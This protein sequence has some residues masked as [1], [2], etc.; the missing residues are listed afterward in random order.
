MV[1]VVLPFAAA[2]GLIERDTF[3]SELALRLYLAHPGLSENRVTRLMCQ[4]LRL[5][6]LPQGSCQQQG[7]QHIYQQTC[8]EKRCAHCILG[9]R[10]L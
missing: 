1:N 10:E 3:L 4:Q 8:R 7:L 5:S 2:I 9:K 6:A